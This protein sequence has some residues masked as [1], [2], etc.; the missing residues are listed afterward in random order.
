MK[1]GMGFY[2]FPN[3]FNSIALLFCF[4]MF[5]SYFISGWRTFGHSL[6]DG[7]LA[8]NSI[9]F[10]FFSHPSTSQA[11]PCLASEIRWDQAR[12]GWYGRRQIFLF[13]RMSLFI[14]H[15]YKIFSISRELWVDSFFFST[16]NMLYHFL[17]VLWLQMREVCSKS[18]CHSL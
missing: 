5:L 11:Q 14:L 10:S 15:S 17:M 16:W 9:R 2:I 13:L 4:S 8:I 7:V 1:R 18:S 3:F 6:S 12:S